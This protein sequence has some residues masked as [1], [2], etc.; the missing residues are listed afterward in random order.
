MIM[1][2]TTHWYDRGSNGY[3]GPTTRDEEKNPSA[4][5]DWQQGRDTAR[6]QEKL[7]DLWTKDDSQ[8]N[9]TD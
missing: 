3:D 9:P 2:S 7:M 4:L 8:K 6:Q 5:Q 1:T